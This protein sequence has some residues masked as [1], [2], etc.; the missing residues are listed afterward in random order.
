[1]SELSTR[2]RT[3]DEDSLWRTVKNRCEEA[4]ER[5]ERLEL[6]L[7]FYARLGTWENDHAEMG[8][9]TVQVPYTAPIFSDHGDRAR[10]ALAGLPD[11][12]FAGRE[13][14]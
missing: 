14:P 6:A 12:T 10:E 9:T 5:I 13:K 3:L 8:S 1:M 2:L 7:E 4:A 11:P